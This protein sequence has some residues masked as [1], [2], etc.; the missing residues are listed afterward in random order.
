MIDAKHG[1]YTG[2]ADKTRFEPVAE[3][4]VKF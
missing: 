1:P 2:E 3:D 4:Q